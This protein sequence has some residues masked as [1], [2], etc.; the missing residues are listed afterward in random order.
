MQLLLD[1]ETAV[2][3]KA[4]MSLNEDDFEKCE[5]RVQSTVTNGNVANG[6]ICDEEN[7]TSDGN[8]KIE[9]VKRNVVKAT[10]LELQLPKPHDI[11]DNADI[12]TSHV[13]DNE[14]NQAADILN[15]KDASESNES[16]EKTVSENTFSNL[17]NKE[18]ENT[19]NT[20]MNSGANNV[21]TT[22]NNMSE[23]VPIENEQNDI[24]DNS[25]LK[26][27]TLGSTADIRIADVNKNPITEK[28]NTVIVKTEAESTDEN[29]TVSSIADTTGRLTM[30]TNSTIDTEVELNGDDCVLRNITG[31]TETEISSVNLSTNIV[32]DEDENRSNA[33]YTNSYEDKR[34]ILVDETDGGTTKT[35]PE[36][37][38]VFLPVEAENSEEQ[39]KDIDRMPDIDSSI[40]S[41]N[42]EK[43]E[44][45]ESNIIETSNED[46][47]LGNISNAATNCKITEM[48]QNILEPPENVKLETDENDENVDL[49]KL[50]FTNESDDIMECVKE[51]FEEGERAMTDIEMN[52]GGNIDA[53]IKPDLLDVDESADN[54]KVELEANTEELGRSIS[55]VNK[56]SSNASAVDKPISMQKDESVDL[57]PDSSDDI[58]FNLDDDKD[59]ENEFVKPKSSPKVMEIENDKSQSGSNDNIALLSHPKQSDEIIDLDENLPKDTTETKARQEN[60]TVKT[61]EVPMIPP[62]LKLSNTLDI[63]SDDE[64]E[65]KETTENTKCI[66]IEDD[67]DVMLIDEDA[68]GNDTKTEPTKEKES[69]DEPKPKSPVENMQLGEENDEK[70]TNTTIETGNEYVYDLLMAGAYK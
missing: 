69:Q 59:Q 49:I 64:D 43:E 24:V 27:S 41:M 14:V 57:I 7:K 15:G 62:V 50:N 21:D 58:I 3:V 42:D 8:K 30:E 12:E 45:D 13:N 16:V 2:D 70:K 5:S 68:S 53:K 67:D 46:V 35:N 37:E 23:S 18:T 44:S 33:L 28:E 51:E 9:Q 20:I 26:D 56:S 34:T 19:Y 31:A 60:I 38:N 66:S 63:L 54:V 4:K 10:E 36:T 61:A 22:D 6:V 47:E 32:T 40:D 48:D 25:A 11:T 17:V 55:E 52:E 65:P 1:T 39:K 29:M